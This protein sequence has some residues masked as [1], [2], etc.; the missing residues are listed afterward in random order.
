M[1]SYFELVEE[2]PGCPKLGTIVL[3]DMNE[4]YIYNPHLW[5]KYWK[6]VMIGEVICTTQDGVEVKG[7]QDVYIVREKGDTYRLMVTKN[8]Y[9]TVLILWSTKELADKACIDAINIPIYNNIV[10][11]ENVS[12][13]GVLS[14]SHVQTEVISSKDLFYKCKRSDKWKYFKSL[15]LREEYIFENSKRFSYNDIIDIS[16]IAQS[17]STERFKNYIKQ[18]YKL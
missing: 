11:G 1:N 5:K 7:G 14:D 18:N 8:Y 6:E 3:P 17:L 15:E 16:V 10:T 13:Y 4:Y 12:L 2:Y 9:N